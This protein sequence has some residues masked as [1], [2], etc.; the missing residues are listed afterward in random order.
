MLAVPPASMV[1]EGAPSRGR[2]RRVELTE[3]AVA[4]KASD[5]SPSVEIPLD[6]RSDGRPD[7]DESRPGG[8]IRKGAI[9][10]VRCDGREAGAIDGVRRDD[11]AA[12]GFAAGQ[13]SKGLP[14]LLG[15]RTPEPGL[16][17]GQGLGLGL[18]GGQPGATAEQ[19]LVE[20]GHQES[21]RIV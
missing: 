10:S 13:C 21:G 7:E 8:G 6:I 16:G 14:D 15:L 19:V 4:I 3:Q 20:P 2:N 1:T 11:L 18:R 5:T 12:D 9:D 17:L